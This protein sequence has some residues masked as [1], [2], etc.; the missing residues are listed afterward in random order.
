MNARFDAHADSYRDE[1]DRAIA[2]GGQ[3]VDFF[4]ERKA[5]LLERSARRLL[6]EPLELSVLDVGCGIGLVDGYLTHSFG[7][8][9]G[10]D[11]SSAELEVARAANP[12]VSYTLSDSDRVPH[13]VDAFDVVFAAC[14][15][16]HLNESD[17]AGFVA[18]LA[19]VVRPGGLVVVF[20]HNP[21]NPLT[22][23]VVRRVAFDEGVRLLRSG[24][25][26][27]LLESAGLEHVRWLYT[28][29]VPLRGRLARRVE[30]RLASLP[31][32]AQYA[33]L[34]RKSES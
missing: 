2:F 3:D 10:T 26:V 12:H 28:T 5:E 7:S 15:L 20:E 13:E 16:H 32:G 14:V 8:V 29:F 17:H 18:E 30:E 31:L 24:S 33:V 34:G 9:A 4:A 22:R 21:L 1:V 19:R 25:V 11:V 23:L 27:S 6:G